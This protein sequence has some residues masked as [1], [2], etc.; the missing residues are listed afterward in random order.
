MQVKTWMR[1][2]AGVVDMRESLAG[3][4]LRLTRNAGACLLVRDGA[5]VVGLLTEA[6]VRRA[7]PSIVPALAVHELPGATSLLTV[8]EA[9]RGEPVRV[10]PTAAATD[11]ARQLRA[12][13]AHAALVAEGVDIMGVVTTTDLLGVLVE[14]LERDTPSSLTRVLVGVRLPPSTGRRGDVRGP[15]GVAADIAQEHGATLTV[16]HVMCRLSFRVAEGLPAG[17]EADLHRW[18]LTEA[19]AALGRLIPSEARLIVKSGDVVRGLLD[20]AAVS[21]ADLIVLGGRPGSSIMR[22]TMRQA[23]CPVLAV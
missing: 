15:L 6:D 21:G 4:A 16:L 23:P 2:C 11:V 5:R 3:A 10:S 1:A 14:R 17:V 12:R 20:A 7:G 22:E 9:M 19:R 13:G 18:R 8:A